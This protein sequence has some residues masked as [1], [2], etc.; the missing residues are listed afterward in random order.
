MDYND[1]LIKKWMPLLV[2]SKCQE[3]RKLILANCCESTANQ[4]Q[5]KTNLD[6]ATYGCSDNAFVVKSLIPILARTITHMNAFRVMDCVPII[7]P[8]SFVSGKA[9]EAKTSRVC[10]YYPIKYNSIS[11]KMSTYDVNTLSSLIC[12]RIDAIL[13]D[14]LK[15]MLNSESHMTI[16]RSDISS[17]NPDGYNVSII[18]SGLSC[19]VF[20]NEKE[21][22]RNDTMQALCNSDYINNGKTELLIDNTSIGDYVI[23]GNIGTGSVNYCP[24]IPVDLNVSVVDEKIKMDV[25]SRYGMQFNDIAKNYKIYNVVD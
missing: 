25:R 16:N 15:S 11:G 22:F 14:M 7:G 17:I 10:E 18:S 1:R 5:M 24:Y 8:A 20:Q 21:T 9:I 13:L 3:D 2:A 23:L 4:L 6:V 19:Q 12:N